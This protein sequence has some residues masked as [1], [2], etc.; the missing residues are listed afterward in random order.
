MIGH[1]EEQ[2]GEKEESTANPFAKGHPMPLCCLHREV[3]ATNSY[4][5]RNTV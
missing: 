2:E 5:V 4:Q 1:K 3:G